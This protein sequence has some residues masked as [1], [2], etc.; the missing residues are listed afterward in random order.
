ME[1]HQEQNYNN[2]DIISD[3]KKVLS[4]WETDFHETFS[5]SRTIYNQELFKESN[6]EKT[7][8]N[9]VITGLEKEYKSIP[10]MIIERTNEY[11]L[12]KCVITDDLGSIIR[13]NLINMSS[14]D[15][16]IYIREFMYHSRTKD[17]WHYWLGI[18]KKSLRDRI[19]LV[20]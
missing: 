3:R 7:T 10:G 20:G 16:V 18:A 11:G 1:K 17:N 9:K 12:I 13:K 5:S 14:K 8:L 15:N 19:K 2:K 6:Q 4:D